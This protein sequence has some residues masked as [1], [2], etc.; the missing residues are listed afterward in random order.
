MRQPFLFHEDF[1]QF[2]NSI[3]TIPDFCL[4]EEHAFKISKKTSF[5]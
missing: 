1:L 2:T 5:L 3:F 4:L